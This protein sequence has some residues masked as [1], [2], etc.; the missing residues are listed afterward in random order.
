MVERLIILKN[1]SIDSEDG[2]RSPHTGSQT[3]NT[4]EDEPLS[5][6]DSRRLQENSKATESD[7]SVQT[8]ERR[9]NLVTISSLSVESVNDR[10]GSDNPL[11]EK[12]KKKKRAMSRQMS[13]TDFKKFIAKKR[14]WYTKVDF[15]KPLMYLGI[16]FL[17]FIIWIKRDVL[18]TRLLTS[19]ARVRHTAVTIE[20]RHENDD[21]SQA[22][23]LKD[24]SS[25]LSTQDTTTAVNNNDDNKNDNKNDKNDINDN[26]ISNDQTSLTDNDED[27][28]RTTNK[29]SGSQK[30]NLR[31][32]RTKVSFTKERPKKK[33]RHL[34]N[35]AIDDDDDDDDDNV[36]DDLV[37]DD[38]LEDEI[39][40]PTIKSNKI[41]EPILPSSIRT[42]KKHQHQKRRRSTTS[43]V[44]SPKTAIISTPNIILPLFHDVVEQMQKILKAQGGRRDLTKILKKETKL[45][46][47]QINRLV[48][49][50]D[51]SVITL[52]TF[53]DLLNSLGA[54]IL[55]VSK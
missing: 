12:A 2:R 36:N 1:N 10:D 54:T 21:S 40:T 13:E 46:Q 23:T 52:D 45:S 11:S 6:G 32:R 29:G 33:R 27:F 34:R 15:T 31:T 3:L 39:D 51:F 4:D 9:R 49:K 28:P 30:I 7:H 20:Q 43:H 41:K 42:S 17:I 44:D 38:V 55:L 37:D 16:L 48:L 24:S 8:A 26:D 14:P 53:I 47:P 35:Q 18:I 25:A 5:I 22:S 50:K 19:N